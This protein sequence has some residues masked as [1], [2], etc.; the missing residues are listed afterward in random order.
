MTEQLEFFPGGSYT[1]DGR[2]C[3]GCGLD[4]VTAR[5]Y[6]MLRDHVWAETGVGPQEGVLCIGCVEGRLGPRLNRWDFTSAPVNDDELSQSP[7]LWSRLRYEPR[8]E[9]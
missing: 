2:R 1:V 9:R 3:L 8:G 4:T 7:R 6:Y 5:E